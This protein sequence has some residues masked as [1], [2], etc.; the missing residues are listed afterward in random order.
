MGFPTCNFLNG[1]FIIL[2]MNKL[3]WEFRDVTKSIELSDEE[4]KQL[5]ELEIK[6]LK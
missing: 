5:K 3:A 1:F 6:K 2:K 4:K